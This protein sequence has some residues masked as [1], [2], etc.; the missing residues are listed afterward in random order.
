MEM[1]CSTCIAPHSIVFATVEDVEEARSRSPQSSH[2]FD[3]LQIQ[4]FSL[5]STKRMYVPH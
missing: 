1:H 4:T 2:F 5:P 3:Y